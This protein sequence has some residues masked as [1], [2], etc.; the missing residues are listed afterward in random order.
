M[1]RVEVQPNMVFDIPESWTTTGDY[2]SSFRKKYRDR[3]K[4]ARKKGFTIV[5]KELTLVEIEAL[6]AD[7]FQLY[8]MVSDGA[9]VNSF[10]LPRDHFSHLKKALNTQFK[11]FAYFLDNKLVG[12]YTLILNNNNLETYFLGYN[13]NLQHKHQ[14]YLNMLYDMAFYAIENH[15]VQVIYARTAMEIKS[16]VGARPRNMH[17]Y[18]KHTNNFIAN[19]ILKIIV[20]YLNPTTAWQER[21]PFK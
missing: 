17:I 7:L 20:R 8:K 19:T 11:I 15:C 14:L 4:T 2:I 12:F 5:K 1:Y 21:H 13:K 6:E 10:V 16:S 9:G 3:Y 18:M